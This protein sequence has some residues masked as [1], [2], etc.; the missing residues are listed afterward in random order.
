MPPDRVARA[1]RARR[2]GHSLAELAR[3]LARAGVLAALAVLARPP[4]SP[5]LAAVQGELRACVEQAFQLAQARGAP[6]RLALGPEAGAAGD[7]PPLVLPR[8]LRWGLPHPAVPL[9]EGMETPVRAHRT[10]AAH[11]WVTVT[12]WGTAEAGAWFVTDGRD[13]AC[14]R[15]SGQGAVTLLRWRRRTGRWERA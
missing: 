9:P 4:C 5:A 10:G 12:P 3:A 7:L 1:G 11:P 15:L 8:G 6:V 2:R 13:A 14:L